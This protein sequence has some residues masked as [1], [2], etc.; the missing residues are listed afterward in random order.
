MLVLLTTIR[1]SHT[2]LRLVP[3][4]VTLN[5]LERHN[6]TYF[7]LFYWIR[8]LCRPITS[9]W[10]KIDLYCLQN[11]V[12]HFWPQLTYPAAQSLCDSRATC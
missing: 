3:T 11:I 5:D 7:A 4:W 6:S 8:L 10:L 12:F 1:K 2:V 9:Q